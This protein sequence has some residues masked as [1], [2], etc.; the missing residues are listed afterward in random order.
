MSESAKSTRQEI[1]E[2]SRKEF[3]V[4]GYEGARLHNI[5]EHIGVTKAMIHYYFNTKRELFEHVYKESVDEIYCELNNIFAEELPL[6]KKIEMLVEHCL[7][8]ADE[9]PQ[10]LSFVITESRR[11]SEW[12]QPI[13]NDKVK[14]ELSDFEAELNK[15]ASNYQVASV[16]V[17]DLLMNIFALCYY[18]AL[19]GPIHESIFDSNKRDVQGDMSQNRKG[20]ILDTVF[21]WLTA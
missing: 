17:H 15:A 5:A 20:V 9:D 13:I 3:L 14:L 2:A 11:K 7:Q 1:I 19:A 12:L 21:N 6:L 16:T 18:P 10:V 4:H 8:K